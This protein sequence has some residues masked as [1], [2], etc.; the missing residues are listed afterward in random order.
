MPDMHLC[1]PGIG[2]YSATGTFIKTF[3]RVVKFK[4]T[5]NRMYNSIILL[6]VITIFHLELLDIKPFWIKHRRSPKILI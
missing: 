1:K 3:Q 5:G 4:E 2:K 6:M